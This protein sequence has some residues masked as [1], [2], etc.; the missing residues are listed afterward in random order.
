M[1]YRDTKNKYR[2]EILTFR[3][4]VCEFRRRHSENSLAKQRH[5]FYYYCTK[6]RLPH[7]ILDL[8]RADRSDLSMQSSRL[9]EPTCWCV[10]R[11]VIPWP[12][13]AQRQIALLDVQYTTVQYLV[14]QSQYYILAWAHT[15]HDGSACYARVDHD[16]LPCRVRHKIPPSPPTYPL[17]PGHLEGLWSCHQYYYYFI[18]L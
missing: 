9:A 6:R 4:R 7:D 14:L 12:T 3:R 1:A 16:T 13:H 10:P 18:Y 2:K 17:S 5:L 11:P 15:T 8:P